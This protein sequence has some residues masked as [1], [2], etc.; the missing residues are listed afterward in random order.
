MVAVLGSVVIGNGNGKRT[1][2][3]EGG[4]AG[5]RKQYTKIRILN[6]QGQGSQAASREWVIMI[7]GTWSG[8]ET[9]SVHLTSIME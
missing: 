9:S 5:G 1:I 6:I 7:I 2:R 3:R 4:G 8:Q